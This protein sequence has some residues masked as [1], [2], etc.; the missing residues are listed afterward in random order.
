MSKRT[1]KL[2][3]YFMAAVLAGGGLVSSLNAGQVKAA[4][5]YDVFIGNSKR[6]TVGCAE[7]WRIVL[8][9]PADEFKSVAVDGKVAPEYA[10]KSV[11]A[12]GYPEGFEPEVPATTEAPAVTTETPAATGYSYLSSNA[13]AVFAAAPESGSAAAS[14]YKCT[15]IILNSSWIDT[16]G[17][18]KHMV[19][20]AFD[21][22]NAYVGIV[23]TGSDKPEESTTVASTESTTA[24]SGDSDD[25]DSDDSSSDS[26]NV[27]QK[28]DSNGIIIQKFSFKNGALPEDTV[29][30]IGN[31]SDDD[32][33]MLNNNGINAK[34]GWDINPYSG[35]VRAQVAPGYKVNVQFALPSDLAYISTAEY[36]IYDLTYNVYQD[37]VIN[38]GIVSFDASH[39]SKY[40]LVEMTAGSGSADGN[41]TDNASESTTL[42]GAQVTSPK[43]ADT[44]GVVF[45]ALCMAAAI[46][47]FVVT[48]AKGRQCK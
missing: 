15:E 8:E 17:T 23:V 10:V 31:M 21:N 43:T 32:I 37:A 41:V 7:D 5:M 20:L 19:T 48:F 14:A 42:A 38:N 27:S 16:I 26:I 25:T 3:T 47:A 36:K 9:A 6:Y 45:W 13:V 33:V 11:K 28:T 2:L 39:F 44:T 1:K 29:W 22:G 40:A 34:L 24:A 46:G 35:G 4:D 18:G 30:M 12:V